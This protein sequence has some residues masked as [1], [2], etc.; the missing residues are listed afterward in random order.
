MIDR[1]LRSSALIAT[2]AAFLLSGCGKEDGLSTAE[3]RQ[4][5]EQRVREKFN[6]A[7]DIPLSTETFV[8]NPL[9]GD[10]V[11]CGTVK[12]AGPHAPAFPPQRFVAATDPARWLKFQEADAPMRTTHPDKFIEWEGHCMGERGDN[13]DEPLAV[14]E[15]AEER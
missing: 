13:S 4:A 1:I 10:V 15:R 14:T 2:A 12:G 6:L 11:I 5:A 3:L 8:G 9:D 7:P